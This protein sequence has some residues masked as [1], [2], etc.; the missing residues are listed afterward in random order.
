[1]RSIVLVAT[2]L[3]ASLTQA[4]AVRAEPVIRVAYA[5]SMGEVMDRF[6]NRGTTSGWGQC[7]FP[8]GG[9]RP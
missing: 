9:S 6:L 7:C 8:A 2:I 5:G 4:V 3:L 1:M